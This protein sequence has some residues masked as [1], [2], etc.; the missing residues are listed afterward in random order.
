MVFD[1]ASCHDFRPLL[2]V[3]L[4]DDESSDKM[5]HRALLTSENNEGDDDRSGL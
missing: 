4:N 3:R 2:N 1:N 5:N